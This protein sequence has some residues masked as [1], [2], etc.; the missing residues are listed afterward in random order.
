MI[1]Q[2]RAGADAVAVFDTCAGEFDADTYRETAVPALSRVLTRFK[3]AMPN[4]PVVYYS[5]GTGPAHWKSLIELPIDC[6]GVDWRHDLST[7]LRAFG[8]RFSI[9]GNFDP[10]M[11]KAN[12]AVF[13]RELKTYFDAIL[14]GTRPEQR[15]GW[16]SGLGHGVLPGT[17]EQN[18]RHFMKTQKEVF[19]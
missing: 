11:P 13:E 12:P 5:R 10:D 8:D 18:V 6:M 9:Q 2:A 19:S 7:V 3:K 17:P 14:K 1:L 4:T 15:R 16:V